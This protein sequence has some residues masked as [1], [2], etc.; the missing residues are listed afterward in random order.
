MMMRSLLAAVVL[1]TSTVPA[2]ATAATVVG[3]THITVKSALSD[4]LQVGELLAFDFGDVNVALASNGGLATAAGQYPAP[5]GGGAAEAIDGAFPVNYDYTYSPVIPGVY[6]SAGTG[7]GEY[8]TVAFAGAKT[9]SK[10]Q[11]YGRGDCCATRD[12]YDVT[13]YGAGNAVLFSGQLDARTA[14]N[15]SILFDAPSGGVPEPASWALMIM[16][17]GASGAL[18]RRRLLDRQA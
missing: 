16:G 13:I 14:G 3:A 7:A 2:A 1:A 9:L 17:F 10:I 8:L 5:E 15:A 18:L 4:F 11:I 12:F 6:H